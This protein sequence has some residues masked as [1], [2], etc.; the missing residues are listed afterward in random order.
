MLF[1]DDDVG[2]HAHAEVGGPIEEVSVSGNRMWG[3]N[4]ED[5]TKMTTL[6]ISGN[7]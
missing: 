5:S 7:R 2:G 3:T 4:G 1:S 6:E